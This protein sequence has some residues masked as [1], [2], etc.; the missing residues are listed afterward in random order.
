VKRARSLRFTVNKA[1]FG[2][3]SPSFHHPSSK[4]TARFNL[5]SGSFRRGIVRS[6]FH[7]YRGE[8]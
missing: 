2:A 7:A 5:V 6:S 4:K 1:D 8:T 3:V